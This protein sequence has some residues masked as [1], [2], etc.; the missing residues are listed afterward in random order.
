M[1]ISLTPKLEALVLSKVK[2]GFYNNASEVIREALR[3]LI[4]RDRNRELKEEL[5]RKELLKGINSLDQ[6]KGVSISISAIADQVY[7]EHQQK[8]PVNAS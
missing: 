2:S 3:L 4:D 1:N 7:Q 8:Q 6:G 5:L